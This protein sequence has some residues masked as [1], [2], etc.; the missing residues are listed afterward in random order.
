MSISTT[1]AQR[2]DAIRMRGCRLLITPPIDVV[3]REG[4]RTDEREMNSIKE[5]F[6][7]DDFDEKALQA[8]GDATREC[9]STFGDPVAG[10]TQMLSTAE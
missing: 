10:Y 8:V 1:D 5:I 3:R 7:R 4:S 6:G 9:A 2:S